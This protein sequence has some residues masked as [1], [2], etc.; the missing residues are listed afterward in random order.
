LLTHPVYPRAYA[1]LKKGEVPPK[2][3]WFARSH[4]RVDEV[5]VLMDGLE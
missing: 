4:E 2:T 5:E 3:G 1:V